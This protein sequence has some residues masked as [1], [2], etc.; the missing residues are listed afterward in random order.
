MDMEFDLDLD[1]DIDS[2]SGRSDRNGKKKKS[3]DIDTTDDH[4]VVSIQGPYG[5]LTLGIACRGLI[6]ILPYL[7]FNT[8]DLANPANHFQ[9]VPWKFLVYYAP[10]RLESIPSF[11]CFTPWI[12][13]HHHPRLLTTPPAPL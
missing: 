5:R 1:L 2:Y 4:A 7:C 12:P 6:Y 10:L 9:R 13:T 3:Y 11:R 8:H